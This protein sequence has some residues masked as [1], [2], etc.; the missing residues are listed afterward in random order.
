MTFKAFK[1]LK[2]ILRKNVNLGLKFDK[3]GTAT[4]FEDFLK[5]HKIAWKQ[6]QRGLK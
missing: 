2:I 1:F 3:N 5:E 4:H 6:A